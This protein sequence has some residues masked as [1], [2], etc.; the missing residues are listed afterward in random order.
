MQSIDKEIQEL[1]EMKRG[2]EARALRHE[3]QAQR[4]QFRQNEH[5][6]ARKH[7]QLADANREIAK[8]IQQD[9]DDLQAKKQAILRKHG[10]V[11]P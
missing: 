7:L 11:R 4:L 3:D 1:T 8:K 9:I 2:Y 10:E 5:L 6:E